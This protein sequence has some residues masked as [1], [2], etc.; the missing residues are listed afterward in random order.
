MENWKK[1][2]RVP[3]KQVLPPGSFPKWEAEEPPGKNLCLWWDN[4]LNKKVLNSKKE[5]EGG[6]EKTLPVKKSTIFL[7][8]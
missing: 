5:R 6:W 8:L 4:R 2:L 1:L 7:K 3:G